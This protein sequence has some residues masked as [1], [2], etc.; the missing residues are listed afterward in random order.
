MLGCLSYPVYC[1]CFQWQSGRVESVAISILLHISLRR[2][3]EAVGKG[4]GGGGGGIAGAPLG[5]STKPQA[6]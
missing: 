4:G 3:P 2:S 1:K 6:A 5:L